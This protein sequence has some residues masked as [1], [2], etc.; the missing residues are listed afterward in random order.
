M[1]GIRLVER[2]EGDDDGNIE[3]DFMQWREKFWA[4]ACTFYGVRSDN[5]SL[6]EC[7]ATRDYE[8]KVLQGIL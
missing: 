2:G 6:S 3:D 7:A 8:L 4:A 5:R 1:G